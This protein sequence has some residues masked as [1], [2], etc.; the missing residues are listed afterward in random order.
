MNRRPSKPPRRAKQSHRPPELTGK[1]STS[2]VRHRRR[3]APSCRPARTDEG[4]SGWRE[5]DGR[6]RPHHHQKAQSVGEAAPVPVPDS[7]ST[8]K[9]KKNPLPLN[10]LKK[11]K[12]SPNS[13]LSV[14]VCVCLSSFFSFLAWCQMFQLS[15][16]VQHRW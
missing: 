14:C 9:N 1:R 16:A 4:A 3:T 2:P 10:L 13:I 11:K 15:T 8:K 5:W 6:P 7:N 12:K